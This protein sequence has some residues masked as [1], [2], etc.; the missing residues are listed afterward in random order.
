MP[1]RIFYEVVAAYLPYR[2]HVMQTAL[3]L[4]CTFLLILVL[5][6]IIVHF[7]IMNEFSEVSEST[8]RRAVI[9]VC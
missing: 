2:A 8:R 9:N 4:L 3:R 7:Q 6:S 1:R 5:F